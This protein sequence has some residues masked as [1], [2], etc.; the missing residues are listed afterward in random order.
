M[1]RHLDTVASTFV[2]GR[3]PHE[4]APCGNTKMRRLQQLIG[5]FLVITCG[6][7]CAH[8]SVTRA[9]D[10]LLKPEV[11]LVAYER[12]NPPERD[13]AAIALRSFNASRALPLLRGALLTEP[14]S[15]VVVT[16]AGSLRHFRDEELAQSLAA[17]RRFSA[18]ERRRIAMSLGAQGSLTSFRHLKRLALDPDRLVRREAQQQLRFLHRELAGYFLIVL[19]DKDPTN[20]KLLGQYRAY[21]KGRNARRAQLGSPD[22]R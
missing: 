19:K 2:D 10:P 18:D 5:W 9:E 17:G 7:G 21:F 12:R 22:V 3:I 11:A 13:D 20:S 4:S 6:F 15:G 8:S 14:V 16:I 1:E